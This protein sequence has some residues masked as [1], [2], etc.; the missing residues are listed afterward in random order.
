MDHLSRGADERE[1]LMFLGST[2]EEEH[3]AEHPKSSRLAVANQMCG[4]AHQ[5]FRAIILM[6]SLIEPWAALPPLTKYV[7]C[8]IHLY[9]EA[10]FFARS[11]IHSGICK[12]SCHLGLV[13]VLDCRPPSESDTTLEPRAS[14]LSVWS[15]EPHLLDNTHVEF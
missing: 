14:S 13:L 10:A 12:L 1:L 6:S 15:D 9:I 4:V 5:R 3:D 8:G 11:S 7:P 2:P